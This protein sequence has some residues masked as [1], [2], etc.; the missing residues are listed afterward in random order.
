MGLCVETET[1]TQTKKES[2]SVFYELLATA[3]G[4]AFLDVFLTL[5]RERET[6]KHK[7]VIKWVCLKTEISLCA[8]WGLSANP[9]SPICFFSFFVLFLESPLF[10]EHG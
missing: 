10:T 1:T 7:L 6:S 5:E 3:Y 2:W 8:P 4:G 9:L